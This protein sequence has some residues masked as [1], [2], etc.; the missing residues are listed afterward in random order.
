MI[1]PFE[2]PEKQALLEARTLAE[3]ASTLIALITMAGSN[4]PP[5]APGGSLQ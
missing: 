4:A 5:A 1:C 3:R 2:A